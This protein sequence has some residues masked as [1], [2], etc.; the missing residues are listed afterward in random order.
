M[1]NEYATNTSSKNLFVIFGVII[2][3]FLM[4]IYNIIISSSQSKEEPALQVENAITFTFDSLQLQSSLY[5]DGDKVVGFIKS[6]D[7]ATL[8]K[9]QAALKKYVKV[10]H[11]T[12]EEIVFLVEHREDFSKIYQMLKASQPSFQDVWA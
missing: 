9:A 5:Q 7:K 1:T 8:K 11:S 10:L 2:V 6:N 3:L 4:L 12:D